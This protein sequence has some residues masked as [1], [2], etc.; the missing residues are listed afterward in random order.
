MLVQHAIVP[1]LQIS[2]VIE[3]WQ[4]IKKKLMDNGRKRVPQLV[5]MG[6]M[7]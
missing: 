6:I 2:R 4:M 3:R 5:K 7:E 1:R